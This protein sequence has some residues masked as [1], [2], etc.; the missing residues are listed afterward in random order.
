MNRIRVLISDDHPIVRSGLRQLLEAESDMQVVGEAGDGMT[1][2]EMVRERRPDVI[3]L[4]IAMPRLSGLE[5]A[6]MVK[7]AADTRVVI[8]SMY[9]KEA[10][11]RQALE[12]GALGYVVKGGPSEEILAAIRTVIKD[13]YY[14]SS[15]ITSSVVST[16][17]QTP[18]KKTVDAGYQSLSERERQ[19]FLLLVE[20]SSTSGISDILCISPKTVEKHRANIAL[21][22]GLSNPVEMLRYAIRIGLIDPEIWKS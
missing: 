20:G 18:G 11:A 4:D 16:Y 13:Q 2:L 3:L 12:A 6:Q 1:A 8:L 17:L 19:V 15:S 9:E 14:L 10:Y 22:L 5:V 21:K 7:A